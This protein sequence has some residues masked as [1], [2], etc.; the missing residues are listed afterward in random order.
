MDV[1]ILVGLQASGKSTF[2]RTTFAATHDYIS[3]D[4]LRNNRQPARRQAALLEAALQ[5][6][7]S[8]VVDNTNVTRKERAELIA[9]ARQYDARVIGYCFVVQVD[10]SLQRNQLRAGKARVPPVAIFATLKRF[11]RPTYEEGFDELYSVCAGDD[12][13][14]DVQAWQEVVADP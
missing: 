3:K 11:A 5:A 1:I 6:G 7:H 9:L 2:F 12:S 8:L 4:L 14:F 13:S 10:K